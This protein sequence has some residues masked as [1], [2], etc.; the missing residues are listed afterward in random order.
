M[1]N[2]LLVIAILCCLVGCRAQSD[3]TEGV[4]VTR[5]TFLT[6]AGCPGS[7]LMKNNLVSALERLALP[8][9]IQEIDIGHLEKTDF[10][11]GYG[12]PTVLVGGKD[13]F[14]R[15]KPGPAAPM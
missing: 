7:P 4:Q 5:L 9:D 3:K 15:A 2:L 13:L 6:R 1:R 10:R 14:G 11:T 8:Y 12:S